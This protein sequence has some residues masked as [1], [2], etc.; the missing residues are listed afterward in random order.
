MDIGLKNVW[1]P[2]FGQSF[3]ELFLS[4]RKFHG[5][6]SVGMML[7]VLLLGIP[8]PAQLHNWKFPV[9]DSWFQFNKR[10]LF[11]HSGRTLGLKQSRRILMLS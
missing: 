8:S 11:V 1:I 3:K 10:F 4:V 2:I 7:P 9:G 5:K 6:G